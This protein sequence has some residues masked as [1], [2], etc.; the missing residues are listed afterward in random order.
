MMDITVSQDKYITWWVYP[1][2]LSML[3]ETES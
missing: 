2:S 3:D 1:A